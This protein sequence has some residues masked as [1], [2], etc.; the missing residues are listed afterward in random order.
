MGHPTESQLAKINRFRPKGT[1]PIQSHEVISIPFIASD[2]L[3]SRSNG[4]WDI[5][6]LHAMA[7][8]FPGRPVSLDHRWEE[9]EK[10]VAFVYDGVVVRTSEASP[11]LLN[12]AGNFDIN[13]QIVAKDGLHQLV[14]YTAV[15][16]TSPVVSGL[17][18]RRLGDVSTGGFTDGTFLCPLCS[19]DFQ[20][21]T[22]PHIMPH[23]FILMLLQFGDEDIDPEMIAPYYIRSG[24]MDA[25]ELSLVV[26]GN[27]PGAGVVT[28]GDEE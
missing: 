16:A 27:L 17:R 13:R 15:E 3:V 14:L 4:A 9:S 6:S 24:F 12:R 21:P 7:K 26:C 1:P 10:N 28:V 19:V 2:N 18:F 8:L 22:C 25:V 5:Q 11:Q 20:D 23:P